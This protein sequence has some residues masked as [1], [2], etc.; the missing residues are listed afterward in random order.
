[1]Y[2]CEQ[3]GQVLGGIGLEQG[4]GTRLANRLRAIARSELAEQVADVFFHGVQGDY[5]RVSDVLV[6]GPGGQQVQDLLLAPGEGD[7]R[8]GGDGGC[9]P[10]RSKRRLP[11]GC[12]H[13]GWTRVL[14][15]VLEG[16]Q[17]L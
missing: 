10:R 15:L 3:T 13:H 5:Q 11:S 8:H 17:Q 7:G 1:M 12:R 9:L 16:G 14:L 4:E 2:V 6:R